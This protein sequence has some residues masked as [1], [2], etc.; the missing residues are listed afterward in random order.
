MTENPNI[1]ADRDINANVV[2]AGDNG[3]VYF[4]TPP[5]AKFFGVPSM[6][7][8]FEGRNNELNNLIDTLVSAKRSEDVAIATNGMAGVGKTTLAVA[9]AHSSK[10]INHFQHGIL[11]AGLGKSPDVKTEIAKWAEAIDSEV[12]INH[13]VTEKERCIALKNLIG[14]RKYLLIV[15]DAWQLEDIEWL[16][17]GGPNCQHLLTTRNA[18]VARE[19][20]GKKNV[21]NIHEFAPQDAYK[22]L[23]KLAPEVFSDKES[24]SKAKSLVD[25]V[26]YLPLAVELLGG[27]LSN[28]P[29]VYFGKSRSTTLQKLND[30]ESRLKLAQARLGANTSNKISLEDAIRLSVTML[31]KKAQLAFYALGA[32]APKPENF[33]LEAALAVTNSDDQTLAL[34]IDANLVEWD[35]V[36]EMFQLHQTIAAFVQGNSLEAAKRHRKY[37]LGKFNSNK[38]NWQVIEKIY[39]QLEWGFNNFV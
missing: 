14:S 23:Q 7:K 3:T 39:P 13:L 37:Y 34:L 6:P 35:H 1:N 17:C 19:F 5:N 11:W 18:Q 20:A 33:D 22:F 27:Y 30:P 16:K 25:S 10:I 24:T 28:S 4:T 29:A 9:I 26:G 32:F 38:A 21:S 12:D 31:P 15:D 36:N 2:L 8:F